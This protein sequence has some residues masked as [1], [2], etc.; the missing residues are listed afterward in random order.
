M[1]SG[2]PHVDTVTT[3]HQNASLRNYAETLRSDTFL[4]IQD[5]S[6]GVPNTVH[7]F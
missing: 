5:R 2:K 7:K 6:S 1:I 3:M 4:L